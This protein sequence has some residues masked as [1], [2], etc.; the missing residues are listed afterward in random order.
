MVLSIKEKEIKMGYFSEQHEA[1]NEY[2][3]HLEADYVKWY[4]DMSGKF[5]SNKLFS[6][7]SGKKY[8]KIIMSDKDGSNSS[9]HSYIVVGP[10]GKFKD[11]D[12]L[13]SASWKAPAKNFARGN[14]FTGD[15]KNIRWT[16][17]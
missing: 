9:S 8:I 4:G 2:C 10:Q 17:I 14:I 5:N 11:G 6:F 7:M 16:G 1:V 13:K 3:Q 15:F 12:I